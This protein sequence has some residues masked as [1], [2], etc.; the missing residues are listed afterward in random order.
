MDIEESTELVVKSNKLIEASYKLSLVEQ[1]MVLFA[2]TQAREENAMLTADT[3]VTIDAHAFAK[4]FELNV[5]SAYS[6]LKQASLQMFNRYVVINDIHPKS[7]K[8]RVVRERW[9]SSAGYVEGEGL[10]ELSFTKKVI[11]YITRLEKQFTSYRLASVSKMTSLYAIRVYELLVQYVRLGERRFELAELK[12]ML[13]I[14]NE[15]GLIHDF[16]ARV[17]DVAV[18]Q[19]N[20]HGDI[21]VAYSQ[22]KNGRVVA[23][24][25]FSI[26]SKDAKVSK[27]K[28]PEQMGLTGVEPALKLVPKSTD[29]A[30]LAERK[31]AL[32]AARIKAK[33]DEE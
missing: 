17:L 1:Q 16:K 2:I 5:D 26:K 28:K 9:V 19:I 4:Q 24:I 10:V 8:P 31:K 18:K 13:G 29:P 27:P 11:P 21:K 6:Q 12:R 25:I 33:K 7:G 15:Y 30:V 3:T 32:S 14:E 22:K 20:K 23:E